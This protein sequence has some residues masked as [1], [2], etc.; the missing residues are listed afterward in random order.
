MKIQTKGY[1][2][3][4]SYTTAIRQVFFYTRLKGDDSAPSSQNFVDFHLEFA[5]NVVNFFL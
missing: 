3:A 5:K 4:T 2:V 1:R